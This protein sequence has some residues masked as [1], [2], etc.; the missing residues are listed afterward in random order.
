MREKR[1]GSFLRFRILAVCGFF[2]LLF[3]AI[4]FRAFQLQVLDSPELKQLAA[5]QHRKVMTV[6][7]KRGDIFD[8]N[9][10]ELAVSVEVDSIFVQPKKMTSSREAIAALSQVLGM[11][12]EDVEDKLESGENFVWVKRRVD[13]TEDQRKLITSIEGLGIIKESRR[14]Y[15]NRQLASNLIGFTGLDAHGLEGVERHYDEMLRG[16]SSKLVRDKDATGRLLLFEDLDKTVPLQGMEVELTIDKTIQ[17]IAEKELK[18]AVDRTNAKGGTAVVMDPRTGEVLAMASMP[19]FDPNDAGRYSAGSMKNKA[20]TDVY[21]PGSIFKLFLISAALEE[22]VIKPADSIYCENGK[23]KVFNRVFHDHEDY[24]WLNIY[25]IM[26]YSSNIGTAKIGE[27]LGKARVYKYVKDFGFGSKTG[28]DLP[29]EVSGIF[30]HHNNWSKVTLHTVSF[31]QGVSATGI[32]LVT[33]LSSIANGGFLMKPYIVKSVKDQ[34]GRVISQTHP[35]VVRRVV[36]EETA[37]KMTEMLIGVTQEGGTGTKAA[38]GDF[39]VAG[40]T[41]TAQ[42]VDPNSRGYARGAFMASF[43]GFVPAKNPRLAI[44]VSVDEPRGAEYYGGQV[45]APVFREIAR[46]SLAYLGVFNENVSPVQ[47]VQFVKAKAERVII[48]GTPAAH[49]PDENIV[50]DVEENSTGVPDFTGKSVRNV[51]RVAKSRSLEVEVQGSGKAVAQK[52][53]PGSAIPEKGPVVVWFQ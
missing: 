20:I 10:K 18:K 9:L 16:S 50:E 40:K 19:T 42:K 6:Q 12:R 29:G 38:L 25:E 36:S 46:Q 11:D 35:V 45:S 28:I 5:R 13:L 33:A 27:R 15:P 4:L 14:Y 48:S 39:E 24:G 41:G 31:G 8:R 34:S 17:Y 44:I 32:Q 53:A 7:S 3:A 47:P 22:K 52:P 30:R 49:V 23:Y 51:L 21:E 26:K 43:F 2:A 1:Q 37:R